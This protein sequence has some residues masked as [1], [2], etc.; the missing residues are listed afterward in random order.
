MSVGL[1][2]TSIAMACMCT[3]SLGMKAKILAGCA[4]ERD[5]CSPDAVV[6][7][8]FAATA[9]RRRSG[10]LGGR[11]GK[12]Y[13]SDLSAGGGDAEAAVGSTVALLATPSGDADGAAA[14]ASGEG[15]GGG[16]ASGVSGGRDMDG[17]A[18]E[19]VRG[20]GIGNSRLVVGAYFALFFV[21]GM[22]LGLPWGAYQV[23]VALWVQ[24]FGP[25][26]WPLMVACYNGPGILILLV[27]K[28]LDDSIDRAMGLYAA[29]TARLVVPLL[30]VAACLLVTPTLEH[31]RSR[32]GLLLVT[33]TIGVFHA[34][35]CTCSNL[36]RF[37]AVPTC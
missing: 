32:N 11:P 5:V 22:A 30:V 26:I 36:C 25:S 9:R 23:R 18:P 8:A 1:E 24:L 20:E 16:G 7:K 6:P 35:I 10:A 4:P 29:Y 19:E 21:L 2:D 28:Q 27:Q 13:T 3:V 31:N 37:V 12:G 14:A 33:L 17:V 15:G 34:A